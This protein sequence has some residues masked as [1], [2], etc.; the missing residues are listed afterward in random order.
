MPSAT[1]LISF[2][3]FVESH[4]SGR[5][6]LKFSILGVDYFFEDTPADR[7]QSLQMGMSHGLRCMHAVE[8]AAVGK[9]VSRSRPGKRV[10]RAHKH[11]KGCEG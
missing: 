10:A 4:R 8:W 2:L 5:L 3:R 6:P 1:N 9:V 11:H 7:C